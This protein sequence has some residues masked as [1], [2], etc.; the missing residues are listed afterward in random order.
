MGKVYFEN[1]KYG[2]KI[3]I[4]LS[5]FPE[6]DM[7]KERLDYLYE[8]KDGGKTITVLESGF[9]GKKIHLLSGD[10][11][12][13][14]P[15]EAERL[16][17]KIPLQNLNLKTARYESPVH[18][19]FKID[20]SGGKLRGEKLLKIIRFNAYSSENMIIKY[21]SWGQKV[22]IYK[23]VGTKGVLT[24]FKPVTDVKEAVTTLRKIE[25]EEGDNFA[26][27]ITQGI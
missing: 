8:F 21:Y 25:R 1:D 13:T 6:G 19:E 14:D 22:K 18:G 12:V 15:G 24:K 11:K 4:S 9:L 17:K 7:A 5:P 26:P 10:L 2:L 23:R 27:Y 3:P 20:L 16:A